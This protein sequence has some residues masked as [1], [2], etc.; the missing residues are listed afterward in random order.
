MKFML[1][2]QVDGGGDFIQR[3]N[4]QTLPVSGREVRSWGSIGAFRSL[5]SKSTAKIFLACDHTGGVSQRL[6][7]TGA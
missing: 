7:D 1:D 3:E 2:P 5:R 6:S 4:F